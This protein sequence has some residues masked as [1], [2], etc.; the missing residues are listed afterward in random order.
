MSFAIT[1]QLPNF[2][3]FGKKYSVWAEYLPQILFME[4]IF[5]YLVICIIY[6]WSVDWTQTDWKAPSLLN[7]LIVSANQPMQCCVL[8]RHWCSTCFC[9]LA[10][11]PIPCIVAKDLCRLYFCSL[12][13]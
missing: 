3:H 7:M 2:R 11:L 4:C 8:I 10:P 1:L 5:G 12:L 9:L 13:S 6:K